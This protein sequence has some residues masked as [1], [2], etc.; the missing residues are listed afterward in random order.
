MMR[1]LMFVL[2]VV[3]GAAMVL[4]FQLDL[5]QVSPEPRPVRDVV[6]P[7]PPRRAALPAEAPST[8]TVAQGPIHF[9]DVRAAAGV[10][11]VHTSGDSPEKPYPAANG[12]GVAAFD[13]DLDGNVDLYFL[14]G[15]QFPLDAGRTSPCN[16]C[17]RN[18]GGWEFVD[19][20]RQ[21]GLGEAGYSAG[22][23]VGDFDADGFPDVFVNGYGRK[24]LFH[25]RG[26]GTFA[27]VTERAGIDNSNWGTG[28]AFFDYDSDGLI[29]LYVCNYAPADLSPDLFCGNQKLG[30]R[31]YCPPPMIEPARDV[32]YRNE[33]DGTFRNA[34]R[35]AGVDMPPARAQ[36]IVAA[37]FNRDGWIDLY[38]ANDAQ[39]NFLFLNTGAGSFR[40]IAEASGT[41]HDDIGRSPSGMGV[42]AAD[43]NHD[44]TIDLF[45]TNFAGE[46]NTYFENLG[47][48]MFREVSRARGLAAANTPYVGWGTVLADFDLDGWPDVIVS[49]GHVD[50]NLHEL[51]R[52]AQFEQ[53]AGLWLNRQGRFTYVGGPQAGDY[54]AVPHAGRALAIA[55]LDNDGDFDVVVVHQ[56]AFPALLRND[57]VGPESG[58]PPVLIVR[59]IG[60]SSNRDA[61]GAELRLLGDTELGVR[62][63]KGGG[64]YFAA[65]DLRQILALPVEPSSL[66]LS[67]RWPSGRE[68]LVNE[69]RAGS[70]L[71]LVEPAFP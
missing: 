39:R 54:F 53:P 24:R 6:Q 11:F 50:N 19:V 70:R 34:T 61:I 67:V 37:D 29:D 33:G 3:A 59:L 48:L 32:L 69:V 28:A 42:D 68:T 45:V 8:Q 18:L 7:A 4:S 63:V 66:K 65:H 12:S 13:F 44:G 49:N 56:D 20:T 71:Q 57:R 46:H 27:D 16:R 10:D 47:E 31:I 17:F 36:G 38:V 64:S 43:G 22:V 60:T 52:D 51:G 25:N 23:A 2:L 1:W 14:T 41:A 55:D 26:D 9:T 5:G 40:E 15:T 21:A 30:I 58:T 35:E 62:Q